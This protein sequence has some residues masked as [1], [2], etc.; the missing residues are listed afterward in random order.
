MEK[1]R[2][3]IRLF[4]VRNGKLLLQIIGVIVLIILVVQG[5]NQFTIINN[6]AKEEE[7]LATQE[8]RENQKIQKKKENEYKNLILTFVDYCNNKEIDK[9]YEML[10]GTCKKEKYPTHNEFEE[11]YINKVFKQKKDCEIDILQNNVFKVVLL[12]DILQ[13]GTI[14][15]REKIEDYYSVEEDVLENKSININLYNNI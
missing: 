1:I 14:E 7:L 9:A 10:S 13:A 11:K 3:E 15:N 4:W 8:E 5:L 12:Q 2:R 6:K